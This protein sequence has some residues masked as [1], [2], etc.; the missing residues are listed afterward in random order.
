MSSA[1]DCLLE[2]EG[3]GIRYEAIFGNSF[4]Q[5]V[6]EV[7]VM[8]ARARSVAEDTIN[9]CTKDIA[10]H[11]VQLNLCRFHH[12]HMFVFEIL[13]CLQGELGKP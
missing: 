12:H 4:R 3:P 1:R 11:Q 5:T 13:V 7:L 9:Q 10:F 6:S 2:L 8:A